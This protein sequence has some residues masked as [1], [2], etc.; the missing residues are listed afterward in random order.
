MKLETFDD[1]VNAIRSKNRKF[2]LLLGNGFSMAYEPGIFSYNALYDFIAKI[3]DDLLAKLFGIVKTKN[4]EL[5]MQQLDTFA[6][7]LDAFGSEK[8]LKAKVERASIKLKKSLIDAVRALHPEHVFTVPQQSCDAC[9]TFLKQFLDS[10]GSIY[11]TNY[12]LLL[13]WVLMRSEAVKSVD[14]FGRD[15]ENPDEYVP[16][17]DVEYSELRWGKY[18]STQNVFYVHGALPLFDTGVE[19]IKEEYDNQNYLL[20]NISQRMDDCEYPIFV[21]AGNGRE[22]LTH[23]MHNRYLSNCYE[24]LSEITGSLV[25]F[26]FNFG[27]YDDHIINA[28][29]IAA[30]HGKK[31]PP[32]LW[33]IYIGVYSE[34]DKHHIEKIADQFRCKVHIFDAKTANVWR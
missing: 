14:G 20:E 6:A 4:F 15:R 11:T 7:L 16:E 19:I 23:I 2:H 10:D 29:N 26:G 31:S 33:S 8:E 30:K 32:K 13:Y 34:E 12:D 9:A 25:T 1:V 27:K 17:D 21:T 3:D 22:K 24:S 5:I 28:I 18:Q